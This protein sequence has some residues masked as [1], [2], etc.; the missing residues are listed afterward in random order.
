MPRTVP[1]FLRVSEA[2]EAD[3]GKHIIRIHEDNK[4]AGINW[5]DRIK[6]SIDKKN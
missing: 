5:G 4:P 2:D 1:L 6:V 3:Y